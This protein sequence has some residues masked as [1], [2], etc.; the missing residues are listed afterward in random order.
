MIA[1]LLE[2]SPGEKHR[3]LETPPHPSEEEEE[4]EQRRR[5][6]QLCN[7]H[8]IDADRQK[9]QRMDDRHDPLSGFLACGRHDQKL[10]APPRWDRR[11][12]VCASDPNLGRCGKPG[13]WLNRSSSSSPTGPFASSAAPALAEALH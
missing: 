9:V 12:Y 3:S 6:E 8:M 4:E 13:A 2:R 5:N 7:S 10:F 1:R 11:R